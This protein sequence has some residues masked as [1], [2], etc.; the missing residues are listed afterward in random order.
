MHV[1]LY[2][3][4]RKSTGKLWQ[5][6]Q[7]APCAYN[8]RF[9]LLF[10]HMSIWPVM[11]EALFF[12]V[13]TATVS[14][15]GLSF[16]GG[17]DATAPRSFSCGQSKATCPGW[18]HVQ[19]TRRSPRLWYTR[20]GEVTL[21]MAN[22]A[23]VE[24]SSRRPV[25]SSRLVFGHGQNSNLFLQFR[26]LFP[27]FLNSPASTTAADCVWSLS[28]AIKSRAHST[29]LSSNFASSKALSCLLTTRELPLP[30]AGVA[31]GLW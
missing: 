19:H 23:A 29:A 26:N 3:S 4:I 31:R 2:K 6:A 16:D 28:I 15:C 17:G 10:L 8:V 7:L 1:L 13:A 11:M 14:V 30:L 9:G 24:A 18:P 21:Q 22:P 25:A 12:T 20:A 27:E 5:L